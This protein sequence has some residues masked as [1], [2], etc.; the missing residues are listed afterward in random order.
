MVGRCRIRGWVGSLGRKGG[1][2]DGDGGLVGW[3]VTFT[4][5]IQ[6]L[7]VENVNALHLA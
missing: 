4:R 7:H 3:W 6:R 5:R 2:G 1:D